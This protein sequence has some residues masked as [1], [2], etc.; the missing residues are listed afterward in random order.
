MFLFSLSLFSLVTTKWRFFK[1]RDLSEKRFLATWWLLYNSLLNRDFRNKHTGNYDQHYAVALISNVSLSFHVPYQLIQE[2]KADSKIE[3]RRHRKPYF[4]TRNSVLAPCRDGELEE[5]I[6]VI[7][8]DASPS[9]IHA[10]PIHV[11]VNTRCRLKGMEGIGCD[12]SCNEL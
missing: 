4:G 9:T 6:A 8:T 3:R 12:Y 2:S 1:H 5:I 10:S 7:V 11:W